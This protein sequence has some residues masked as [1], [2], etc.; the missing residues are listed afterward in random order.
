MESVFSLKMWYK[1]VRIKNRFLDANNASKGII[2]PLT[3]QNAL[4]SLNS[5]R[6]VCIWTKSVVNSAL[7][8]IIWDLIYS[9]N[10][11]PT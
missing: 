6:I 2:C 10:S 4:K 11:R 5:N 3:N 9:R 7:K 8:S 1:T